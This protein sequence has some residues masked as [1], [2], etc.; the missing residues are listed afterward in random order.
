[1][2][3][4]EFYKVFHALNNFFTTDLSAT[5]LDILKDRLYTWKTD[6]LGRRSA[7][8]VLFEMTE[9]TLVMMAPILS[10]LSEEVY[11]HF[12]EKTGESVFSL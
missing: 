3:N 1:M 8:T 9:K 10:F 5:Y 12:P 6:G 4:Y 2:K 11:S 7:Q